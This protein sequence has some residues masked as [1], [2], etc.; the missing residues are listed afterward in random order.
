MDCGVKL[1]KLAQLPSFDGLLDTVRHLTDVDWDKHKE[2]QIKLTGGRTGEAIYLY[3]NDQ[4]RSR[5]FTNVDVRRLLPGTVLEKTVMDMV[6]NE[7]RPHYPDCQLF[8]V[9]FTRMPAGGVI[10]PHWDTG[11]LSLVH[12]LHVP[13][14]TNKDVVFTIDD[15]DFVL[16]PGWLY[17]LNNLVR[18]SVANNSSEGRVHLLVDLLPRDDKRFFRL[19][20]H[21]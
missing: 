17:E 10:E 9:Q 6:N 11:F 15:E 21:D 19:T 5:E 3:L 7:I 14:I 4:I 18:H 1:K 16:E 8:R 12:R 13:V 20:Y 2:I